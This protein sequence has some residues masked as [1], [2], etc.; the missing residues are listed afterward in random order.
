M[1]REGQSLTVN[2]N[3]RLQVW[4]RI[5]STVR[6][7][8]YI[9]VFADSN[10]KHVPY[11]LEIVL[12]AG[13]AT[14][15]LVLDSPAVIIGAML[16][17]P[18]MGPI[19]ATGLGLA[20]GDLYLALKAVVK[21]S[22]SIAL[23]TAV[24]A[25]LVWILPFHSPTAEILSRTKPTLL[26]LGIALLSGI[27]GS[28]AVGRAAGNTDG[29]TTVPGVAIA[30]ALMP[31][32]CT[33]GFGVGSGLRPEI[34]R[35]AALLFL[36]NIVAIVFSAFLVFLF[37]GI[38]DEEVRTEMER[39]R[40]AEPFA[41][42]L[43][44]GPLAS[45]MHAG[46]SVRWRVLFLLALLGAVAWPLQIAL[47]QLTGEVK[48]REI[49]SREVSSLIP[50]GHLV[51]EQTVVGQS[52]VAVHV[53][54][55]INVPATSIYEAESHITAS[56]G[57]QAN[58]TVEAIASQSEFAKLVERLQDRP[59]QVPAAMATPATSSAADDS[60]A[61]RK[62]IE[63]VLPDVW[64]KEAPLVD[65]SVILDPSQTL[66]RVRYQSKAR[67]D[68]IVLS[69]LMKEL[70]KQLNSPDLLLEGTHVPNSKRHELRNTRIRR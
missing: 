46:G 42:R 21:L 5:D 28:V 62:R 34:I 20:A 70:Q 4:L 61:L 49:V 47:R 7:K 14:L 64:P 25:A 39:C 29:L 38:N 67:L 12:S 57:R 41:Q 26:D 23:A 51:S 53:V 8:I 27:A 68:P 58:I 43:A 18:L 69:V 24:S 17:S 59:A 65:F 36:T 9:Q 45:A 22:T 11:W 63:K 32:L 48:T 16:I 2:T 60:A 3:R 19:M 35:G 44:R 33:F 30:V 10:L 31:P 15:G 40:A 54:A 66:V 55:T 37:I 6:P 56:S 13:I 50:Q 1:G 52:S